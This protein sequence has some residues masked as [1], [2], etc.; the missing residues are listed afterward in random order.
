MSDDFSKMD[1]KELLA[2]IYSLRKQVKYW[3]NRAR[4]DKVI[5]EKEARNPLKGFVDPFAALTNFGQR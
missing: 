5:P 3:R 1:R 2:E 4:P